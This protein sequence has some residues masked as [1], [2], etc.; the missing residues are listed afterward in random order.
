[1]T[2]MRETLGTDDDL[3]CDQLDNVGPGHGQAVEQLLQAP[4]EL[5]AGVVQQQRGSVEQ[6]G[7]LWVGEVEQGAQPPEGCVQLLLWGGIRGRGMVR[8]P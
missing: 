1:M 2:R 6:Q 3:Q 8:P 5:V 7:G 4:L